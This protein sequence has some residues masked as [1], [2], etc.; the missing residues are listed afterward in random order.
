MR[1]ARKLMLN[2]QPTREPS[3]RDVAAEWLVRWHAGELT[4]AERWEYVQWLKTSPVHI[5][6]TLQL[7]WLYSWMYKL[8]PLQC[9]EQQESVTRL[10]EMLSEVA[11]RKFVRHARSEARFHETGRMRNLTALAAMLSV[12]IGTL[13]MSWALVHET[14]IENL[15]RAL[16]QLSAA[17]PIIISI[18]TLIAGAAIGLRAVQRT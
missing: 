11:G 4:I 14:P 8:K 12:G 5:S 16:P 7:C 15:L 9:V 10:E 13:T 3:I 2:E 6:E 1:R 17:L 18:L